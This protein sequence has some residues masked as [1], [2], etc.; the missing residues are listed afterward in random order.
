MSALGL[1][2]E[3]HRI[4]RINAGVQA[5]FKVKDALKAARNGWCDSAIKALREAEYQAGQATAHSKSDDGADGPRQRVKAQ[6]VRVH[7][8]RAATE[9]KAHCA[10]HRVRKPASHARQGN[11]PF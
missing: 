4:Q 11:L 10:V 3:Q 6:A 8:N 9:V 1:A 5:G 2:P 7:V